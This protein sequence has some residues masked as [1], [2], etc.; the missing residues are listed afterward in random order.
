MSNVSFDEE[1]QLAKSAPLESPKK[2]MAE[3]L[4]AKGIAKNASQANGYLLIIA[5]IAFAL[6]IYFFFF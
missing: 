2:G 4:V 3:W 5:G 6:A 1:Q